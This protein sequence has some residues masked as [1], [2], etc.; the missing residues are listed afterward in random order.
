MV[1]GADGPAEYLDH[2][3]HRRQEPGDALKERGLARPVRS[4]QCGE[5]TAS[6]FAGDASQD[7]VSV[8]IRG[9]EIPDRERGRPVV[10]L[11]VMTNVPPTVDKHGMR[12]CHGFGSGVSPNPSTIVSTLKRMALS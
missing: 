12:A 5:P 2:A 10:E 3:A 11:D 8:R 1:A 7:D 9:S 6:E 4:H